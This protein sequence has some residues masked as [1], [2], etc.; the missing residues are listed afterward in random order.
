M[1]QKVSLIIFCSVLFYSLSTYSQINLL[2]AQFF[3]NRYLANP[4]MAG[5]DGG[6][7]VNL[8]YRNQWSRIQGAPIDQ[9][10]TMDYRKEKVGLGFS[11]I[12][13]KAGEISHTKTYATYSYT[14]QLNDESSR[15]HFGMNFG[16][17]SVNFNAQNIVGNPNDINIGQFNN[18]KAI[19]DGDFGFGYSSERFTIDGAI[20]N[21]K[22]Q[23]SQDGSDLMLG[24]DFNQFYLGTGYSIPLAEW[25]IN[26]K[27][28]YRGIKNFTD[29]V[30]FGAELRTSGNKLGFSSIYHTNKSAT[31]GLSYLNKDEWQLLSMYNTVQSPITNAANGTFE[32][33]LQLNVDKFL[34][35]KKK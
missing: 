15:L 31:F 9:N 12:N 5:L 13:A 7:K 35:K 18:R 24:A 11:M 14:L 20:Y 32:F 1:K 16:V 17:Q 2:D 28:A 29:L 30:D 8:G 21:M 23:I 33:A 10:F 27:I 4:A 3:H 19:L 6:L 34:R 22:N 25:K 26:T